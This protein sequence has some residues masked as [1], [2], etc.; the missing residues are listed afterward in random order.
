MSKCARIFI[1]S[2]SL[3]WVLSAPE[4]ESSHFTKMKHC[5]GIFKKLLSNPLLL[6]LF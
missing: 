3:S 4:P 6:P 5:F 2:P 1:P